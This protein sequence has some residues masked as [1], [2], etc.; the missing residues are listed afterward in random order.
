LKGHHLKL[1]GGLRKKGISRTESFEKPLVSII[2]IVY[3]GEKYLE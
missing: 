3:N 1:E 2:T